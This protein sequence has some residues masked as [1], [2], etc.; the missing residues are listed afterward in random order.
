M[1][2]YKE[3][4]QS[5][6]S[7]LEEVAE[8][9]CGHPDLLKEFAYFLPEAVQA[10]ASAR[11]AQAAN[12]SKRRIHSNTTTSKSIS[13]LIQ[14]TQVS[15]QEGDTLPYGFEQAMTY[16]TKVKKECTA[17]EYNTFLDVLHRY[18]SDEWSIEEVVDQVSHLFRNHNPELLT[19]F[20]LF[21]PDEVKV[22]YATMV[23]KL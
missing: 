8:L 22:T 23:A 15:A 20:A 5:I 12:H 17:D 14:P 19:E 11:L 18:K 2:E 7:V 13:S 3:D 6:E 9:F 10:Q 1:H 21:L 16:V 4:K